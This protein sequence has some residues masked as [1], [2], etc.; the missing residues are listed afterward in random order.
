MLTKLI[1]PGETLDYMDPV[2]YNASM[3]VWALSITDNETGLREAE[4]MIPFPVWLMYVEDLSGNRCEK[5]EFRPWDTSRIVIKENTGET[6]AGS[7]S[8]YECEITEE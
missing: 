6:A 7:D 3:S 8:F 1:L 5:L 4:P 2:I